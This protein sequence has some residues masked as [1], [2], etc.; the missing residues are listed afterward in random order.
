MECSGLSADGAANS[1]AGGTVR[2]ASF[3]YHSVEELFPSGFPGR[4]N[5]LVTT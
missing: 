3:V 2:A 4:E 5:E 1:A